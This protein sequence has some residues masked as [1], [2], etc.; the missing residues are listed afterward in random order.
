VKTKALS[1]LSPKM[2]TVAESGEKTAT[3]AK[4]GDGRTFLRQSPCRRNRRLPV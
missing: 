2:T 3:V 1:P 4:F